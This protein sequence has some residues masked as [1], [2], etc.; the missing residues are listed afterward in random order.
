MVVSAVVAKAPR[1]NVASGRSSV[2]S[3]NGV[4]SG[5]RKGKA[6]GG[7]NPLKLWPVPKGQKGLQSFLGSQ[8]SDDGGCCSSS[9]PMEAGS[10]STEELALVGKESTCEEGGKGL[11]SPYEEGGGGSEDMPTNSVNL[12]D[13]ITQL[14]SDSDED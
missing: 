8:T 1:K 11:V 10:S 13:D 9:P 7:G 12:L 6:G 5:K 3:P 2:V 14:N 4:A